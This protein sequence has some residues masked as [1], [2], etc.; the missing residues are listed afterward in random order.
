VSNS[1]LFS[2]VKVAEGAVVKSSVLFFDTEINSGA[3]LDKT[4]TDF[5]VQVGTG[6]VIGEGS[7]EIPNK[8]YPN[9]LK[10]GISLIGKDVSVPPNV[11]IGRN[12][13]IYPEMKEKDFEVTK[14]E[15]G[16]TLS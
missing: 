1:I 4:I 14:V 6:C 9:L 12:C 8:E 2:G 10:S 5:D 15:S 16:T 7:H 11:Q 13:I 3:F